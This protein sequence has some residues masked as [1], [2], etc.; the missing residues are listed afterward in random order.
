MVNS[1]DAVESLSWVEE[2]WR[3]NIN[4]KMKRKKINNKSKSAA[5]YSLC[6][7]LAAFTVS[8]APH[9]FTFISRN[10]C[11]FEM[12][13][14]LGLAATCW[15]HYVPTVI[16]IVLVERCRSYVFANKLKSFNKY[17]QWLL[18]LRRKKRKRKK[19]QRIQN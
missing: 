12:I 3:N 8:P 9:L 18:K 10:G 14:F 2:K 1:W 5:Y 7:C 13:S 11:C 19:L 15:L 4:G 6:P 16:A 17:R